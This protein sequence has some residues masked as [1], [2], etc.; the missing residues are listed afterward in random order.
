MFKENNLCFDHGDIFILPC[1][2]NVII[3]FVVMLI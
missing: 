2:A 1:Y 3:F